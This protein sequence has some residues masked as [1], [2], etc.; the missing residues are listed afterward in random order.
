MEA[1]KTYSEQLKDP[2][3]QKKR[4]EIMSRDNFKCMECGSGKSTLNVHHIKY[5]KGNAPWQYEDSNFKTLCDN[6]H[7]LEHM[8]DRIMASSELDKKI[9]LEREINYWDDYEI[10]KNIDWNDLFENN[11]DIPVDPDMIKQLLRAKG[12]EE[13]ESGNLLVMCMLYDFCDVISIENINTIVF[14]VYG[15]YINL[16]YS[17]KNILLHYLR[18]NALNSDISIKAIYIDGSY[19][20]Y[21]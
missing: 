2:R 11:T 6:C 15:E 3:W 4:L 19:R 20:L 10:N 8:T 5:E 18:H 17:Y 9:E 21:A 1:K 12:D 7:S 13:H 14:K 16:L